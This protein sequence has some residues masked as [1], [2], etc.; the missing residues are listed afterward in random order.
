VL[1]T[2]RTT[3][4]HT[5]LNAVKTGRPRL[6]EN[7]YERPHESLHFL[8]AESRKWSVGHGHFQRA[9]SKFTKIT[10]ISIV[11]YHNAEYQRLRAFVPGSRKKIMRLMASPAWPTMLIGCR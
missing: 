10:A 3:C 9:D 11:N 7:N 4:L 5:L 8:L 6:D 2:Q 1:I